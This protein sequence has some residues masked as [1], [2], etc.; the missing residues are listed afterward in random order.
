MMI[1]HDK[2]YFKTDEV[3]Q[4]VRGKWITVLSTFDAL[5][6]ALKKPGRH[7]ACP[8]TGEGKDGF[9]LF[10]NDLDER[11]GGIHNNPNA[12]SLVDGFSLLMW[13]NDWDFRTAVTEVA[14]ILGMEPYRK[15]GSRGQQ[16]SV[17]APRSTV[18]SEANKR[19]QAAKQQLAQRQRVDG[20]KHSSKVQALWAETLPLT[21]ASAAP[22]R[23]YLAQRGIPVSDAMLSQIAQND[24]IRFHPALAYYSKITEE[25]S[26]ARGEL[27]IKERVVVLGRY[28]A[29]VTA[30]RD[31]KGVITTLHRTYLSPNGG[32]AEVEHSRKMM[33]VPCNTTVTGGAIRLATPRGILGVAEGLETA[34]AAY[35]STRLPT[36]SC[37]SATLLAG[38][39]PPEG[40]HTL[41]VWADRDR[42]QAGKIAAER[43]KER[44]KEK[45]INVLILM[46]LAIIPPGQKG[47]DWND[48][49]LRNGA[50]VFPSRQTILDSI[51]NAT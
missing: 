15:K 39:N 27:L 42:S 41:V 9:R 47:I 7:V 45:G 49:L 1:D 11:G 35:T 6:D 48:M 43:L 46:P 51:A 23:A 16:R 12:G 5:G 18:S 19:A 20:E 28:P 13:L 3:K 30:I 4:A 2:E 33:A 32:K 17:H 24:A 44:M 22:A 50:S 14:L 31:D 25:E 40:I 29:I 21:D 34:L 26:T 37:V 10:P 36:W 8:K 38:F